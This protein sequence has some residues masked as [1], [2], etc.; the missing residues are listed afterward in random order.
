[1]NEAEV[2]LLEAKQSTFK[3]RMGKDKGTTHVKTSG[4]TL[5]GLVPQFTGLVI[6]MLLNSM[7][8]AFDPSS[9]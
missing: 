8:Q 7:G 1:M 6:R 2:R 4:W 9:K 5:N 3:N